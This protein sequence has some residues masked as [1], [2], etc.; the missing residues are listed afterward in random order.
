MIS[1]SCELV[2]ES[3]ELI[4]K[5]AYFPHNFWTLE[6]Y[7]TVIYSLYLK[8]LL[9][10]RLSPYEL[11]NRACRAYTDICSLKPADRDPIDLR[12]RGA[13]RVAKR[14]VSVSST[15]ARKCC[16]CC[17]CRV[18][19]GRKSRVLRRVFEWHDQSL[20]RCRECQTYFVYSY[21]CVK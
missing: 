4:I 9:T 20:D 17:C 19:I 7:K 18:C 13:L 14:H 1:T 10:Q 15:G 21:R 8:T 5:T 6:P 3:G 16:C 11:I 12:C 2:N